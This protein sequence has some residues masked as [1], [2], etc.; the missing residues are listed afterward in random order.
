MRRDQ[1]RIYNGVKLLVLIT[2]MISFYHNAGAS[3]DNSNEPTVIY[4]SK[5][6][7]QADINKKNYYNKKI[8]NNE[9]AFLYKE[10]NNKK[11]AQEKALADQ[12]EKYEEILK[13]QKAAYQKIIEESSYPVI[14]GLEKKL[15]KAEK[16]IA[17][18]KK[19]NEEAL[20]QKEIEFNMKVKTLS[21]Q[22]EK[23]AAEASQKEES[24]QSGKD[25]Q[26]IRELMA[27]VDSL[28]E[29]LKIKDNLHEEV[30]KRKEKE[31]SDR[32][33]KIIDESKSVQGM[34]REQEIGDAGAVVQRDS[35]I[36]ALNQRLKDISG[37][38]EKQSKLYDQELEIKEKEYKQKHA[39]LDEK[40]RIRSEQEIENIKNQAQKKEATLRQMTA[41]KELE[42][43]QSIEKEKHKYIQ[44]NEAL[45]KLSEQLKMYIVKLKEEQKI[46]SL[47]I[48][49]KND[50]IQVLDKNLALYSKEE[51][52]EAY[53]ISR[54]VKEELDNVKKENKRY[55]GEIEDLKRQL[56]EQK[57]IL[58][59]R[60]AKQ[61]K[62]IMNLQGD[63]EA[64]M[65]HNSFEWEKK[66]RIQEAKYIKQIGS[67]EKENKKLQND[68]ERKIEK[69][70]E[71]LRKQI[72]KDE[73][74]KN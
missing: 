45:K 25:D 11:Q 43:G 51:T 28:N 73:E 1:K 7:E 2:I 27:K 42:Y 19:A 49:E 29:K 34:N 55:Q 17:A 46:N 40:Y 35:Q 61:K 31:Y 54:L 15:L 53:E 56:A 74:I 47:I 58:E 9:I 38:I 59:T 23:A 52:S 26:K 60:L 39:E 37:K 66:L 3:Q 70:S 65:L 5:R 36:R 21:G 71:Q 64:E 69:V 41:D 13:Q 14:E 32:L 72:V 22:F 62:T 33:Q 30:L 8:L 50:Q 24:L 16:D 10:L 20:I 44:E 67:L 12:K 57:S 63:A 4:Q 18:Q 68:Y 48:P 6:S